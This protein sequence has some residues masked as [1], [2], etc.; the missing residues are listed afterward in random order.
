MG[1]LVYKALAVIGV[2]LFLC[3]VAFSQEVQQ[4]SN[5][6]FLDITSSF[7]GVWKSNRKSI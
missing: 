3:F 7:Q 4:K 1:F 6:A 5:V 2:D